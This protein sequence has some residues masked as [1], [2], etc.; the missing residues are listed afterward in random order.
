[1]RSAA[2]IPVSRRFSAEFGRGILALLCLLGPA[3]A[4]KPVFSISSTGQND[5]LGRSLAG[6]G[7][8]DSD[9]RGDVAVGV[10]LD[11]TVAKDAGRV[12]VVSGRTGGVIHE[13]YG[14]A[15]DDLF[16]ESLAGVGDVDLDGVPDIAVGAPFSNATAANAGAAYVFSG[17][18][19]AQLHVFF[20][21]GAMDR[22]GQE[23]CAAGDVDGDGHADV[24]VGAPD[25]DDGGPNAGR[26][27]VFSGQTG[28]VIHVL[29]GNQP[30]ASF[31]AA[32][33]ALGDI[34][35]DSWP[36]LAVGAP[37]DDTAGPTF[38]LVRLISGRNGKTL[39]TLYGNG[40][41]ERFGQ[42]LGALGDVDGDGVPD[43]LVGAPRD[44]AC[45]PALAGSV[46]V[47][48]GRD[49]T[50]LHTL[51]GGA[52]G[53]RFG[54]SL[55]GIGD[56][57][58]D[59]SGDFVVGAHLAD[60]HGLDSGL[61]RVFSGKTAALLLQLDGV[62]AGDFFGNR[63]AGVGDVNGD[64]RADIAV[65]AP[66][67]DQGALEGGTAYVHLVRTPDPVKYCTGKLNSCGTI[68]KLL[69][70]GES[71]ASTAS[72]FSIV[73]TRMRA[74]GT[75]GPRAG[76]LLYSAT[77]RLTPAAPFLGGLLCIQPPLFRAEPVL[78][79]GGSGN[80]CN[81]F[82]VLDMNAFAAG[83]AG[84]NPQAFLTQPGTLVN[85]QWWGR[86]VKSYGHYLGSA[87]EYYVGP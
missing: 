69:L 26:A 2:T 51:C 31:G 76:I 52:D 46:F 21:Q 57:D 16:G 67:N 43:F 58:G 34:N 49:G 14:T 56:T 9:G 60:T 68:P 8:V 44:G 25:D 63:V 4:Q 79:T 1:M 33:A 35:G 65:G 74:P 70:S 24:L 45:S 41:G 85:C 13:L 28:G 7:D 61:A 23:V 75:S 32:L 17:A 59:G 55:A 81:A 3:L 66:L 82:L 42:S 80:N 62:A 19:G 29:D 12:R 87:L 78:A 37:N 15:R 5:H 39:N 71:S 77:G 18:S 10:P 50:T 54:I 20:G 47:V 83:Q 27:F 72:G 73:G 84:G 48:S 86:D 11:D 53:D 64:G 6:V 40:T 30:D 36:D 38:G 22:F